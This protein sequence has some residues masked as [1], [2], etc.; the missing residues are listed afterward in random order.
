MPLIRRSSH[1][2][3]YKCTGMSYRPPPLMIEYRWTCNGMGLLA[4]Y[5]GSHGEFQKIRHVRE[6]PRYRSE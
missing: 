6:E 5:L 2:D 4:F 1:L 3:M